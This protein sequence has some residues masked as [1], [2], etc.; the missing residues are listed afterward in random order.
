M[1]ATFAGDKAYYDTVGEDFRLNDDW[2]AIHATLS[3]C[4]VLGG[5]ENTDF[6]QVVSLLAS[7]HGRTATTAR[8]ED[9]LKL[10]L[11]DYLAWAPKVRV[12]LAW[13]AKFLDSL[14]IHVASDLPYPKLIEV[15]STRSA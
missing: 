4:P 11:E 13:V 15:I 10:E 14:N 2:S 1:T 5:L 3:F 6:L 8:K 12:A 7:Y 9:I